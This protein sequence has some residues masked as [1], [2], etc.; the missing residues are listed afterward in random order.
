MKPL[1][2]EKVCIG[3]WRVDPSLDEIS[4]DGKTVKLE[5]R[6]M[7]LLVCLA[8]HAPQ[9]VSVE[10]LLREAWKEVIV[11][12]DSVYHVVAA[13]RR[14]LGDDGKHCSYIATVPRRGYRLVAPVAPWVDAHGQNLTYPAVEAP[15]VTH[16][17]APTGSRF[18]RSRVVLSSVVALALGYIA[19]DQFWLS[20]PSRA[21][22]SAAAAPTHVFD[23]SIAVLPF[24][25][26]SEKKDQEYFADGMAEEIIDLLS[27]VPDL[28]VPARTSSFYFKGKPEE[29]PTIAR[30][31]MVTHVL[32]GSVRKS[33]N[34]FRISTQL[35]RADTG[36][37][38]WSETFDR[39]LDDVFEVQDE[40]AS[41]VVNAL[42]VSLVK[43][44]TLRATPTTNTEA[45]RLYLRARTVSGPAT[46]VADELVIDYLQQAVTLDP[47]F[48]AAWAALAKALVEEFNW[49]RSR[50][51][52][53]VRAK[54]YKAADEALRLDP[55]L[56]DGHLAMAITL[57]RFDWDWNASEAEFKRAL[58]LDPG[59]TSAMVHRSYLALGFRHVDQA[60]QLAQEAVSH[61]PLN[62]GNFYAVAAAQ[63][64]AGRFPEAEAALRKALELNP[65]H[66]GLHAFL[67][68]V[69]R[70]RG[71]PTA[72]L[73][74]IER[75]TDDLWR[76]IFVPFALEALGR[77]SDADK[78]LANLEKKYAAQA[79]ATIA[80]F[81][82]CRKDADRAIAWLDRAIRQHTFDRPW[83]RRPCFKK[84][85]PDP[86]YKALLR[87]MNRAV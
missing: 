48:A 56:S 87:E 20:R 44:E 50:P 62:S 22:H 47:N 57:A 65:T 68:D 13:L 32:E 11:T 86:R 16:S 78:E 36:Y 23:R 26:M 52:Q 76:Q 28:H 51:Y 39:E 14:V 9:V 58:E 63:I 46:E 45:Y 77:K 43:N 71:E 4:K 40:I 59:N 3:G 2:N 1:D 25:D 17:V 34:H 42:K 79:P 61:D 18:R 27:K 37:H 5:P 82:A 21:E 72:A 84:L 55:K 12:P 15:T 83:Y 73:A 64:S 7:R 35:V 69:L 29:V 70:A 8:D 53:E 6:A 66:T 41:A 60:L 38:V 75:E 74:E 81:Y 80:E 33:G 49:H 85:E 54:A 31:L 10:Q 67:G 19:V 30:R 24:V